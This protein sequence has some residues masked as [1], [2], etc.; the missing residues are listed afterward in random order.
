[1]ST[2]TPSAKGAPLP[3]SLTQPKGDATTG[4]FANDTDAAP[5][6]D[7]N[8]PQLTPDWEPAPHKDATLVPTGLGAV[9]LV[10]EQGD[11]PFPSAPGILE[12]VAPCAFYDAATLH[13]A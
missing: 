5:L 13:S 11:H 1:M 3:K 2:G 4:E 6:A 9:K 10:A 8:T 12:R 7:Q